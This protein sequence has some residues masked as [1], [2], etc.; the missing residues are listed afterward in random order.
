ME[1]V[2]GRPLKPY[3]TV[4]HRD[5]DRQHNEP[6]NLEVWASRHGRG[7]RLHE[8]IAWAIQLLTDNGYQVTSP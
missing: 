4:H 2:L 8:A 6:S 7:A 5:G 3:E 1:R